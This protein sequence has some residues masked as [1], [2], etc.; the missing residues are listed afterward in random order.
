MAQNSS[1]HTLRGAGGEARRPF[2]GRCRFAR[3]PALAIPGWG[4]G[5]AASLRGEEA[6]QRLPGV[7]DV[8]HR[9]VP[10]AHGLYPSRMDTRVGKGPDTAPLEGS[11]EGKSRKPRGSDTAP[12]GRRCQAS[13]P[14]KSCQGWSLAGWEVRVDVVQPT[15]SFWHL[16]TCRGLGAEWDTGR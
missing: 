12:Y 2:P 5:E 13:A 7:P 15:G 8:L 4:D 6:A 16:V 9:L 10:T 11:G 14:G 1:V 3:S